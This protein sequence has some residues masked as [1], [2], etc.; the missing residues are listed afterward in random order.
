MKAAG[1]EAQAYALQ[2]KRLLV[3]GL[4]LQAIDV[5]VLAWLLLFSL[6]RRFRKNA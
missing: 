5:F 3:F 1:R 6:L 2:G 4:G